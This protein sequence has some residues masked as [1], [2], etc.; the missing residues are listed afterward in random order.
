MKKYILLLL[1]ITGFTQAQTLQ[2]PT[3]GNTTTN[4]LKIKTPA[5]STTALEVGVLESDGLVNKMTPTNLPIPYVPLNYSVLTQTLG[6]HI[7]GLD[8]KIGTIVA[9][10]AGISTRVWFTADPTTITAGTFYL[11]N[12]TGKGSVASAIQNV[13]NNDNVKTYFAQDLIGIPFATATIFPVG[14]Y[15]G[16]LSAS[17]SPNSAQQ[18]WTVE[19][20]KC[21]NNGTPIASGITGAPVGSLGVTVITILDSGL[22]T[23]VDGS[24][25]N[26]PVSGNLA[27]PL[28]VAVGER[29]RYHVS[30]EKVGTA[31]ANITQ[32]V[33]YG[34]SY[35][36]YL[37]VPIS[38]RA[39]TTVNDSGVVGANVA[40]A[41][42]TLN[43]GKE[44]TVNK[45]NSLVP[46][47]TGVKYG[48]VDAINRQTNVIQPSV[49][50]LVGLGDS[51][52]YGAGSTTGTT[53]YLDIIN[54]RL[55]FKSF[56]K[57]AQSGARTMPGGGA[58]ELYT[59]V[60][61]IPAGTDMITVMIGINDRTVSTL[62]NITTVLGKTFASL[63]RTL[64]FTEAFRFN[65]E[66]IKRNFPDAKIY[67]L[68]PT[69]TNWTSTPAY[70]QYI[71]AE[72]AIANYL[73][74]PV[75][76][77]NAGSG[78][79][80][81]SP[82]IPD[83]THPNDTGYAM[84]ADY[85]ENSLK[86]PKQTRYFDVGGPGSSNTFI[87]WQ[88]DGKMGDTS[89]FENST[90]I[91]I[92]NNI[93]GPFQFGRSFAVSGTVNATANNDVLSTVRISGN[94]NNGA[95]TGV[96]NYA[97]NLLGNLNLQRFVDTAQELRFDLNG[98]NNIISSYSSNPAK[99][100]AYNST[101]D[102]ANTVLGAGAN[103]HIFQVRGVAKMQI[104]DDGKVAIQNGGTFTNNNIDALQ[105]TGSASA[106][107]DATT[108][109]QLVRKGQL[110]LKADINSQT[111]TGD[112]KA[113]TPAIGDNDTSIVTSAFVETKTTPLITITT[114]VSITT[115]T[116]NAGGLGQNGRHVV[117]DNGA[118]AI[119][120]T[121]NGGVTASYGKAG[122]AAITFVQ[123][124]GRTLVQ[125]DG[126][127]VLN[128]IAGS[129]AVLWSNGTIDYLSIINY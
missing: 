126:T 99:P 68:T 96:R 85:V 97:L 120:I 109:N 83:T 42:N 33:Y 44:N 29:I 45:Q 2:N 17:T 40:D 34:S 89:M 100:L 26:V 88:P 13:V 111:F 18:R 5:T 10:T 16:N 25:T 47:G 1:L 121:C 11:T 125:L 129:R 66:T 115:A 72:I 15:A 53:G 95:F 116:T 128:G 87:K 65:L 7:T 28:S 21:D 19:L 31:G 3:F 24:V 81:G 75:I 86:A 51:V 117:I 30:A 38:S 46:D 60:T 43:I 92:S 59:Q 4:T 78:I 119:N 103:G 49:I 102:L 62:G 58:P 104:Y 79:F 63:D 37:D 105:V 69:Q 6:G 98:I 9:T 70:E 71:K 56:T 54:A 74:I 41:L 8:A 12:A 14:V 114:A 123:G 57:L 113:P 82:Y 39:S 90:G 35:N 91:N 52:T 107:V 64:S 22:L 110:D 36:S 48:T 50:D 101:T 76:D 94:F 61:A 77:T 118:S 23:L 122:S 108:S 106:T 124:S 55:G 73:S 80:Y 84:I 32:S 93:T 67:V 112:P 27:S 127:A 20:Y